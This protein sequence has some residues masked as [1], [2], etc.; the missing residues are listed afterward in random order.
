VT[1]HSES[2]KKKVFTPAAV[3]LLPLLFTVMVIV[4]FS[5]F[6]GRIRG[7]EKTLCEGV[8]FHAAQETKAFIGRFMDAS[9]SLKSALEWNPS[10]TKSSIE[11]ISNDMLKL[12][13]FILGVST[14]PSAIVKYHFPESGNE[15]LI[16]HDLL[17]NPERRDA[18]TQAAKLKSAVISGPFESVEGPPVLFV[19]YP[20]FASGKLWGF[21]S[22]T[23]D[24]ENMI[25]ALGMDKNYPGFTF[26]FSEE[27]DNAAT[28]T[29][30]GVAEAGAAH[31]RRLLSGEKI[32]YET[33]VTQSLELPGAAWSIHVRPSRGW[34]A[35]DPFLYILLLAGLMGALALYVAF[36]PMASKGNIDRK[37]LDAAK[38]GPSEL[39]SMV[40]A[41]RERNLESKL[42]PQAAPGPVFGKEN[43]IDLSKAAAGESPGLG[44]LAS[45]FEKQISENA[46]EK[47]ES[48][49]PQE[50]S[51]AQSAVS[52]NAVD[53]AEISKRPGREVT[54]K[55]PDVKG[56]LYMPDVL[57]AGDPS[58]LFVR[59]EEKS[60]F[61]L[62]ADKGS[63]EQEK[64]LLA[65]TPTTPEAPAQSTAAPFVT[66]SPVSAASPAVSLP[67]RQELL[68]SLEEAPAM[69]KPSILVVDD[70]EANRD[71]VSRML[72]L[73]GYKADLAA[74]GEEALSLCATRRYAIIFM[75]CFMPGMDGYKTSNLLRAGHLDYVFSIVGMSARIGDQELER[76]KRSGMDDLL[77]KPFTLKDLMAQ[78]EK[79]RG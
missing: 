54:F 69:P 4:S 48:S 36:R 50:A 41:I 13:P 15:S 55:G 20:V 6:S 72:S 61:G 70:S 57:F 51:K 24:F 44:K 14:A 73:R 26:A 27:T 37:K 10:L 18:L 56:Q 77:A 59:A 40:R 49:P 76:C 8:A 71:I 68:F 67:R 42:P 25:Q 58:L 33:G 9:S 30:S 66:A 63:V 32:V 43:G 52:G 11:A 23:V 22:L 75:D 21:V 38:G 7:N 16:G 47:Q 28:P 45:G 34:T 64:P 31:T 12:R 17:S 35:A 79:R 78:I 62:T 5:I 53:P 29:G 74:S 46:S 1:G 39:E 65:T 19:R 3:F 2:N 60:P